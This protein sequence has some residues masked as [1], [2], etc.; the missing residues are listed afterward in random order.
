M[1]VYS[2][3][4]WLWHIPQRAR[5]RCYHTQTR[6][7]YVRYV[8][9]PDLLSSSRRDGCNSVLL[10]REWHDWL[11]NALPIKDEP[12]LTGSAAHEEMGGKKKHCAHDLSLGGER[13]CIRFKC[14]V[15]LQISSCFQWMYDCVFVLMKINLREPDARSAV[16]LLFTEQVGCLVLQPVLVKS[17]LARTNSWRSNS[18][19]HT[20]FPFM[21]YFESTCL[22]IVQQT[23]DTL[24][25]IQSE[26]DRKELAQRIKS[27]LVL[28]GFKPVAQVGM[29]HLVIHG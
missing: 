5:Q 25:N 7:Q 26:C 19:P 13:I 15:V 11:L 20:L 23:R 28:S 27:Q 17:I 3:A 10:P 18:L 2:S 4:V 24:W 9:E 1:D 16:I 22:N 6:H 21:S 29:S 12:P 8:G 14:F